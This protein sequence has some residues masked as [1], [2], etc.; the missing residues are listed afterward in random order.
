MVFSYVNGPELC[1][2]MRSD[3]G[4]VE[5]ANIVRAEKRFPTESN[6]AY[7]FVETNNA[8]EY[9]V[10]EYLNDPDD[11]I[12]ITWRNKVR[13]DANH[14]VR[15]KL[16]HT[17]FLPNEGEPI[18]FCQNGSSVL[19]GEIELIK[20]I[21]PGPT[22]EGVLTYHIFLEDK[23]DVLCTVAGKNEWMDGQAAY[24]KNWKAYLHTLRANNLQLPIPITYGY[25]STAHKSQGNEYRRATV[26]LERKDIDNPYFRAQTILPNKEKVPFAIRWAYTSLTRAKEKA[27]LIIGK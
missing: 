5:V 24:V 10:N 1:E 2:I 15:E 21:T 4:I 6:S 18:M 3:D 14:Y 20:Q 27:T 9:A 12:L 22:I 25:C 8:V 11:H 16:G 23:R 19:N 13:M 7:S 26:M 17:S